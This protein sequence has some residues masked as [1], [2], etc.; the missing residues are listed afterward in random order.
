MLNQ[1]RLA[2]VFAVI[3]AVGTPALGAAQ[4]ERGT[5]SGVVVD[6]SK[7]GVPGVSVTVTNVATNQTTTTVSSATGSY[8]VGNLPPGTYKVDAVLEGFR[9]T[10][11]ANVQVT[12][13]STSRI[14]ATME[15]GGVAEVVNVVA[16]ASFLQTEDARVASTV[17][18]QLIDQLPL[19]VGGAMRSVFDLVSTVAESKGTGQT[20]SIGGGQGGGYS[21]SLDGILITTNRNANTTENAFLTPS[22]EAITEF[23]V[24]SNGFKPEFG[25]A[26]GGAIT[27][28]S[29]SGTNRFQGSVYEFLRDE[30]LDSKD[31]FASGE[32][33]VYNQHNYG[34]SWGGPIKRDKTF[35]FT[36]YE[37]FVN[38]VNTAANLLSVQ[39][40]EMWTGDFSNLVNQNGTPLIIYD[41]ATTRPDPNRP[42]SFIRDPFPG[43]K[44]PANRFSQ[45]ARNYVAMAQGVIVPNQGGTPG[46][47]AYINN[48]FL[49]ADGTTKETTHKF[50]VKADHQLSTNQR[51][52]Y[53]FNIVS[54]ITQPGD[55]GPIGLPAPFSNADKDGYDTTAHRFSWDVTGVKMVNRFSFGINTLHNNGYSLNVGGDWASKGICLKGAIDCN[56]NFGQVS[57]TEFTGWGSAAENG[58]KQPRMTLKNDLSVVSGDHTFKTGVTFDLQ[59]AN[60]FGEQAIAGTSSFSW[61]ETAVPGATSQN[62]GGGS[63]MASF[64]L[65]YVNSGGTE[66]IREVRQ[67]YPYFAMYA[68]DDWRVSNRLVVNYGVRYEFTLGAR[69]VNDRYTDLDPTKPNPKVNNY[70]GASIFAGFGEGRENKRSL[71]DN[72]FGAIAPRLS[73]SFSVNPK[74]IF[75]AGVGRS[76]GR[77]T[78][79]AGSSHFAG[80]IGNW[81]WSAPDNITP[82]YMFDA[83]LPLATDPNFPLPPYLDPSIDNNLQT[84]WWG[85]GNVAS[86]PGYY[87]SWTISLQRELGSGLTAEVDYNGSYG[88]DL[89][90]ALITANQVPMAKVEE[91]IARVGAANVKALLDTVI[92][93]AAHA[94]ALGIPLPYPQFVDPTIQTSRTVA[95]ALRPFPQYGNIRLSVGG[96]DKSGSSKYHAVVFKLNQRMNHGLSLQ[97]S[98][99]WSR[100]MT[101]SD[102]FGAG[103]SLD[104]ARPELEWSIGALDQTH[105][106]KINTVYELPFGS[107]RRWLTEGVANAVLG[108]WRVALTQSYVSGVPLTVTSNSALTIFNTTNRPNVTGQPWKAEP[109]GEEFDPRVDLFF[110]KAAFEMPVGALGNAPRTNPDVRRDWELS[111]NIS[112]AKTFDA[113][114]RFKF[115]VRI[116]AFNMFN[117]IYWGAPNSNFSSTSFGQITSTALDPRQMQ[118]G[119]KMYW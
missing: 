24:E 29:K 54:N 106:I 117:R 57:F 22:V 43:N 41:P 32:P 38:D 119:L 49:A 28:A 25:Q 30:S 85:G 111:E 75:R 11:V 6:S 19:V 69:E 71:I 53:L 61:R 15:I 84:D 78:V 37:G 116:E 79:P 7:A 108:G 59:E 88:K 102:R 112:I 48:N 92:R 58:T 36:T 50:S 51:M 64:L 83:G 110:N 8:S 26:A 4:S 39:T 52:S 81:R 76:F 5:I 65:G 90:T 96:G 114:G 60:G 9:T 67:R 74:T 77:V 82:A 101:D 91:L 86:R 70:P 40:P 109:A 113:T 16:E 3:I 87:D 62:N 95:Q 63:S 100:M 46:T 27:F 97:S 20:A 17:S 98:Y 34:A 42:G 18:N 80:H 47:Y 23:A 13:G 66:Q 103:A 35:F 1:L 2:A 14:D 56:K 10:S 115:D 107:G 93:D 94:Q 31:F 68:Q 72:Y 118:I 12:A 105:N 55:S 104:T 33:P 73:M 44:I 99:T 21:A 89:P 45:L